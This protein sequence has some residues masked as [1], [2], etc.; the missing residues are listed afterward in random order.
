MRADLRNPLVSR[1]VTTSAVDTVVH[2]ATMAGPGAAGGRT[3]MK[4][5]NV[6][7]AMQLLAACQRSEHLRTFVLKSNT[8]VYGSD[9]TDPAM[10]REEDT[11]ST[12][13]ESGFAKDATEVEGYVRELSRRRPDID[14]T[15]L[16]FAN[17]VGGQV[18]SAF[19]RL[20]GLPAVPTVLGYDPR[21]QFCHEDDAVEV[22]RRVVCGRH[23]GIFNVAGDGVIYLSQAIRLAG[24]IPAPVPRPFVDAVAGLVYRRRHIDVSPEQLRFLQFGRAIDTTR[25]RTDLGYQPRYSSRAAFEDFV[26]R[27]RIRGLVAHDEVRRLEHEVNVFL[28]RHD[29]RRFLAGQPVAEERT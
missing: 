19:A 12:P 20:F 5:Q 6:I 8:A 1:I 29:Q 17:F 10:F 27:R 16:R 21:L 18:D 15:I 4:E 22:L 14:V 24:R 2:T 28:A 26:R 13:P 25:L 11:P 23:P 7:G 9:H 3:R